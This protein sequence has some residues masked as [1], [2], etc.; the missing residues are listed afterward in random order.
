MWNNFFWGEGISSS[1][2]KFFTL[3]KK[4]FKIMSCAQLGISCRNLFSQ[5]EIL[6]FPHQHVHSLM[7]FFTNSQEIFQT[8][9]SVHN[10]N[11]SNKHH[12]LH[13]QNSNQALSQTSTFYTGIKVFNSLPPNVTILRNDK[14]KC[15]LKS[16]DLRKYLHTHSVYSLDDFFM[17]KDDS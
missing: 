10:T 14:T 2:G 6:P 3:Q 8:N 17:C 13:Q 16:A 12:H 5:L 9:S 4:I 7:S 15:F 11:T 1:S